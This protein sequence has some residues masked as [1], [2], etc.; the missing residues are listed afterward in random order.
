MS[1]KPVDS[2][3]SYFQLNITGTDPEGKDVDA[4]PEVFYYFK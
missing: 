2:S 1:Q 4:M 3:V